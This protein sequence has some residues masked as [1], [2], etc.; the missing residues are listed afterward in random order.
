[1][2]G[3]SRALAASVSARG[4]LTTNSNNNN[5]NNTNSN[6]N[7]NNNGNN[8]ADA[9][10]LAPIEHVKARVRRNAVLAGAQRTLAALGTS[11]AIVEFEFIGE[12]GTGL[13]PT[14]EF[15]TLLS[16]AIS[17][18]KEMWRLDDNGG[19]FLYL[20]QILVVTCTFL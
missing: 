1:M 13:G 3:A 10:S 7:G 16:T 15:Y 18:C 19:L 20:T 8:N 17:E 5:N 9:A 4:D 12:V 11:R 14:S 2:L 6:N